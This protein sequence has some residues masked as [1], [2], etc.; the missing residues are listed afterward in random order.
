MVGRNAQQVKLTQATIATYVGDVGMGIG[1]GI[2]MSIG[3]GIEIG[4]VIGIGIEIGTI[5]VGVGM[6]IG[7]GIW[8]GVGLGMVEYL[9]V[10]GMVPI[11]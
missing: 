4:I 9:Y 2:W 6:S 7:G 3:I 10:T 8:I 11:G 1:A 5:G